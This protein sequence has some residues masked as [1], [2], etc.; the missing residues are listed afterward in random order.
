MRP[1]GRHSARSR[2]PLWPDRRSA[3][4]VQPARG[5]IPVRGS[6]HPRDGSLRCWAEPA[7]NCNCGDPGTRPLL[8]CRGGEA[9]AELAPVGPESGCGLILNGCC[10]AKLGGSGAGLRR[11]VLRYFGG[12]FR[13]RV[14]ANGRQICEERPFV[15][16]VAEEFGRRVS[17]QRAGRSHAFMLGG[18]LAVGSPI[19][20][21]S[22][23]MVQ[24]AADHDAAVCLEALQPRP[25]AVVPLVGGE[26]PMKQAW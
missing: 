15:V 21:R 16:V 26:V 11:Y 10:E 19:H 9:P 18:K 22:L 6:T 3:H 17:K 13:D 7:S 12:R 24:N 8:T 2:I 4:H 20:D 25:P 1:S 5:G 23:G 14:W